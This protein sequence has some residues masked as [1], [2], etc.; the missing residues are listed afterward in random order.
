MR[1]F[2]STNTFSIDKGN[3][4]RTLFFS[5]YV[6]IDMKDIVCLSKRK[7]TLLTLY[8][9]VIFNSKLMYFINVF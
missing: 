5:E 3:R 4:N 7:K 6:L 8:H 2:L 9:N 1:K